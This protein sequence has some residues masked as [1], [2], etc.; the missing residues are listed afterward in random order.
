M[1]FSFL[2][3]FFFVFHSSFFCVHMSPFGSVSISLSKIIKFI[4]N[5]NDLDGIIYSLNGHQKPNGNDEQKWWKHKTICCSLITCVLRNVSVPNITYYVLYR[6]VQSVTF[7]WKIKIKNETSEDML[8]AMGTY[9]WIAL[10]PKWQTIDTKHHDNNKMV[11]T[12][13]RILAINRYFNKAKWW[14]TSANSIQY[15][16]QFQP[17]EFSVSL[18]DIFRLFFS[19]AILIWNL[20]W[21]FGDVGGVFRCFAV[22][23]E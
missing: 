8:F 16:F 15:V 17:F 12:K 11:K 19:L 7:E 13:R 3:H 4:H 22:L 9:E 21:A 14:W 2:F 6:Y 10:Y 18:K 20:N 23:F 5:N 1:F